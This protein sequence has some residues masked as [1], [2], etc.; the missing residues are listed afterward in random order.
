MKKAPTFFLITII[1]FLIWHFWPFGKRSFDQNKDFAVEISDNGIVFHASADQETISEFLKEK[2]I[3]LGGKDY[4]FPMPETKI[5]PGQKII[6]RRAVPVAIEVDQQK[7][8]LDTWG[9]PCGTRS[10]KPA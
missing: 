5:F 1:F 6:I 7:I 2:N 10:W 8:K 4:I 3:A 9:Q